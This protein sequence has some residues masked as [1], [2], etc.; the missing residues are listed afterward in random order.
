M[1]RNIVSAVN[2]R[3][4]R[5]QPVSPERRRYLE[6]L[7]RLMCR[8]YDPDVKFQD[9]PT[10]RC[11][12]N[13]GDITID[14]GRDIHDQTVTN[15]PHDIWTLV[16]QEG[17]IVHEIGHV[18]YT[19]FE[20]HESIKDRLGMNE[21]N[22]FHD[23]VWN[24]AED[25]AIEEQLRWK[26][27]CGEELDTYNSNL[28]TQQKEGAER[29][30]IPQAVKISILEKG[31]YDAGALDEHLSGEQE[32]V[33]P[34]N[35]Q[36]FDNQIVPEINSM[37]ADVMTE[38]NPEVRYDRMLEFWEWLK[39]IMDDERDQDATDQYQNGQGDG[40]DEA[41]PD[42]T[43]GMTPGE[44]ADQLEDLDEDDVR[45]Q[46]EEIA[47]PPEQHDWDDI[48]DEDEAD[49]DADGGQVGEDGDEQA[50][51][52]PGLG[53]LFSDF[54]DDGEDAEDGDQSGGAG[55]AGDG[56]DGEAGEESE[57]GETG[58]GGGQGDSEDG[59]DGAD[60]GDSGEGGEAGGDGGEDG[61]GAEDDS[62]GADGDGGGDTGGEGG[63]PGHENHQLVIRE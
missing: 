34:A 16:A 25:A 28:F 15:F 22:A 29:L 54:G 53:D 3:L 7:A 17:L 14:V 35:R 40:Y 24:P 47:Q 38:P 46:L 49:G 10:A 27:D 19:D 4:K 36:V 41:K 31:C 59:S 9:I 1:A 56:D 48:L 58:D 33:A 21:M 39:Q 52:E 13:D 11:R 5:Q 57:S 50:D 42:D 18:L 12:H 45:E 63:Y 32:L 44:L 55:E 61:D 20:A 8:G 51:D 6:Q 23:I 60:S 30:P 37:L 2:D 62:G 43:S 26:F